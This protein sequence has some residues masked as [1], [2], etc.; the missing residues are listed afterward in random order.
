[1]NFF[2]DFAKCGRVLLFLSDHHNEGKIICFLLTERY[3]CSLGRRLEKIAKI[4]FNFRSI[5]E[6]KH[7]L[8]I[9]SGAC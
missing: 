7:R 8:A 6:L 1:M 9:H 2:I 4:F 3:F 5:S